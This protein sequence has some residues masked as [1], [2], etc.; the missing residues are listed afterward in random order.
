[1]PFVDNYGK[2]DWALEFNRTGTFPLDRSTMFS[3]YAD[4]LAYAKMDGTDSRQIGGTAYIGQL[5]AVYGPGVDGSTQEVAAYII[6]AVGEGATLQKLAQ[7]SASG[8]YGED[9]ANLRAAVGAIQG[10]ITAIEG[11]IYSDA[12]QRTLKEA[13]SSTPGF[14][15]AADK[16]KLD[17]VADGAQVNVIEGV[18]IRTATDGGY[19][20]LQ[21]VAKKAQLDLSNYATKG[22]LG[23]IPKFA[24]Q[25]VDELP[26][27]D[28]STTTIYLVSQEEGEAAAREGPGVGGADLGLGDGLLVQHL[29]ENQVRGTVGDD[30]AGLDDGAVGELHAGDGPVVIGED[31]RGL[32]MIPDIA[33]QFP[34]AGVH[35]QADLVGAHLG[36]PGVPGDVA[37][38]HRAVV[39]K[40]QPVA[41]HTQ[42]APVGIEDIPGRLGHFEGFQHLI[43]RVA[44]RLDEVGE[45]GLHIVRIGVAVHRVGVGLGVPHLVAELEEFRHGF[46]GARHILLHPV[47]EGLHAEGHLAVIFLIGGDQVV[48]LG[49]ADPVDLVL[50]PQLP[51][52]GADITGFGGRTKVVELVQAGLEL[53]AAPLEAGGKAAGQIVLFQQ[54]AGIAPLQHTDGGGQTA[55]AGADDHHVIAFCVL[56]FHKDLLANHRIRWRDRPSQYCSW[57]SSVTFL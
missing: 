49:D 4:A 19:T 26:T 38:D 47:D 54:Q 10:D 51:E 57:A 15:S 50:H 52:E 22:D 13:T 11:S 8:D 45:M 40:A 37:D 48:G 41:V 39:Q 9:I 12:E 23:Q 55:V 43:H 21:I 25:V 42:I 16:A 24:I 14:M 30:V 6:T 20:D 18:A 36:H 3:S 56:R 34:D 17:G 35:G 2:L 5:I 44:A 27:Q 53:E 33:A 28:I 1:M 46:A 7:S 29:A 32:G 31:G